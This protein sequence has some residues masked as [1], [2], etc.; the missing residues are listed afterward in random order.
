LLWLKILSKTDNPYNL[1]IFNTLSYDAQ[2]KGC[3]MKLATK[4]RGHRR[5]G[6]AAK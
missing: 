6:E 5:P 4:P 2:Q 1:N 3:G